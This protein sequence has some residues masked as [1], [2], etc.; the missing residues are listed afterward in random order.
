MRE[1]KL[2]AETKGVLPP[3]KD[4]R[5]RNS[6]ITAILDKCTPLP[7]DDARTE[8]IKEAVRKASQQVSTLARVSRERAAMTVKI[9]KTKCML[10]G[11]ED[12]GCVREEDCEEIMEARN[13]KG[14]FKCKHEC[15]DCGERFTTHAG[16]TAHGQHC[17]DPTVEGRFVVKRV[18]DSTTTSRGEHYRVQWEGRNS[19]TGEPWMDTWQGEVKMRT[20]AERTAISRYHGQIA[21]GT[22]TPPPKGW[23]INAGEGESW[24]EA[25]GNVQC[26]HCCTWWASDRGRKIHASSKNCAGRARM[27]GTQSLKAGK[28]E[29]ERRGEKVR[30]YGA[31]E[32]EGEGLEWV[33]AFV[34]LGNRVDG[35]GDNSVPVAYRVALAS[36]AFRKALTIWKSAL[37]SDTCKIRLYKCSVCSVLRYGADSYTF[38]T[39]EQKR[40]KTFNSRCMATITGREIEEEARAP[41]FDL[42]A[43]ILQA[44]ATWLGHILRMPPDK[45]VHRTMREIYENENGKE[46]S[47]ME[48]L[49][50]H[51]DFED[52]VKEARDRSAWN[53]FVREMTDSSTP[54]RSN[55]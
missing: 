22:L 48:L 45:Y 26:L 21:A 13:A 43:T 51:T 33:N 6:W 49:P 8:T 9:T 4:R 7:G 24:R 2:H 35:G 31:V 34:Y 47:L 38:T 44:R 27:R 46:G 15:P 10:V 18:V 16:L 5:K 25:R 1:L 54:L 30:S 40:V 28:V 29:R 41:T 23:V 37:L 14:D 55:E 36:Q 19:L 11:A 3:A 50:E 42:I 17:A 20:D 12:T 52:L 32:C 39:K 53:K